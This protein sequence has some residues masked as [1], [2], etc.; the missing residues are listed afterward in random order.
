MDGRVAGAFLS[1]ESVF[2]AV[3][4][5]FSTSHSRGD[6][7]SAAV[8]SKLRYRLLED[9]ELFHHAATR[10]GVPV[11]R[12]GQAVGG[13]RSLWDQLTRSGDGYSRW[14]Y[15]TTIALRNVEYL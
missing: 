14:V 7:I 10:C 2:M 11:E 8:A 13:F 3:V 12:L 5:L 15:R 1:R 6:E 9:D 4:T